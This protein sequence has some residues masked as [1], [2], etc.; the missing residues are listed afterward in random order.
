MSDWIE[1]AL[2]ESE[3][4][5]K[6]SSSK[7]RAGFVHKAPDC[8]T[9]MCDEY[10]G[11]WING[12]WPGIMWMMYDITKDKHYKDIA[13]E[14]G[15]NMD[16][17]VIMYDLL[18]HDVGFMYMLT[19][20]PNYVLF[21]DTMSKKRLLFMA[22]L[23]AGRFNIKGNF[24]RAWEEYVEEP[25]DVCGWAIIDGTM[26]LPL[27]FWASE[28]SGD[29]RFLHI[30]KAHA[31]TVLKYFLRSDGSVNHICEF[32]KFTGQFIKARSGQGYKADS[33]WARGASWAIHGLAL[34]YGYTKDE[35]Y[36]EG[37]KKAAKYFCEHLP[38]DSVPYWDLLVPVEADT[39]R[40]A[41]AGANAASGMLEIA[42]YT[43]G[44][45]K[46]YFTECAIN[47]LK[48]LWENYF[49]HDKDADPLLRGSTIHKPAGYGIN[50]S[51]VYA[52]FYFIEALR[53]LQGRD[54][55]YLW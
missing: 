42:K 43:V 5:L 47:I 1:Q 22:D 36:L 50:C 15:N 31:D 12:Y 16:N 46:I 2:K 21:K 11:S 19:C 3:T 4:K 35:R 48:S 49:I 10:T 13:V 14:C 30:A 37:A 24:I 51:V 45:E 54:E 28:E 41:S 7:I 8:K 33:A 29:P 34:A 17:N 44:E 9:W 52:D 27:L 18:S 20:K 40:D 23:L 38:D 25:N 53:K 6:V 55:I 39:P 26:N 32:D